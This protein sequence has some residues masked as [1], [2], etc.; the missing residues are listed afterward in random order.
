MRTD[1]S[2]CYTNGRAAVKVAA[3]YCALQITS[4]F[5]IFQ[6]AQKTLVRTEI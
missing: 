2:K 6:Q 5:I 3:L 1:F 4:T